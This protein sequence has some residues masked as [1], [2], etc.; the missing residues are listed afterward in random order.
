[1]STAWFRV[2]KARP[3]P[4]CGK[5]DYCGVSA[6]GAA[7]ICMRMESGKSTRN[8]GWLH[9]L[10]SELPSERHGRRPVGPP[11]PRDAAGLERRR[12]S[13]APPVDFE[14]LQRACAEALSW[15]RL[16]QLA[17]GLR[18][19]MT[20]LRNMGLGWHDDRAYSFPMH[21]GGGTVVGLRLRTLAGRKWA[22][23]GSRNGLFLNQRT[24]GVGTVFVCEGA[25]DTAAMMG[26]GL[27]AMGV[28]GAGQ[29][30]AALKMHLRRRD[31]V[32][33]ADRDEAGRRGADR[34]AAGLQRVCRSVRLLYPRIG[35]DVREWF[36]LRHPTAEAVL[37]SARARRIY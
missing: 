24:E 17:A 20:P 9:R 4:I 19:A 34:I 18:V 22:V 32:V 10:G 37:T 11:G 15:Q 7:A 3:C 2:S 28:P 25:S 6:D 27:E 14:A 31:V 16:E 12:A 26:L 35:K 1:M 33:M 5:P 13:R 21:D 8:G 36:G 23:K 30:V 29:C